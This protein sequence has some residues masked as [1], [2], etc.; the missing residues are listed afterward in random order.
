MNESNPKE[1]WYIYAKDKL[2]LDHLRGQLAKMLGRRLS[3]ADFAELIIK[4]GERIRDIIAEVEK[5]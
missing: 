1:R 5:V 3:Q 4:H 2:A